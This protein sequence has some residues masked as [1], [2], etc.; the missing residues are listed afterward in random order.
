MKRSPGETQGR[1]SHLDLKCSQCGATIS[2]EKI[3]EKVFQCEYCGASNVVPEKLWNYLHPPAGPIEGG[4]PPPEPFPVQ[5]IPEAG[6]APGARKSNPAVIVLV[7]FSVLIIGGVVGFVMV[8]RG[9]ASSSNTSAGPAEIVSESDIVPSME[10][11]D[12]DRTMAR[13]FD[14][15]RKNWN[16]KALIGE[17]YISRLR[18]DGTVDLKAGDGSISMQF[19]VP[20]MAAGLLPGVT[21]IKDA[22]CSVYI[23]GNIINPSVGDASLYDI[24]SGRFASALPAC[25]VATLVK[26]AHKKGWPEAGFSTVS[27]PQVPSNIESSWDTLGLPSY[28]PGRKKAEDSGLTKEQDAKLASLL[29]Q[30]GWL[31]NTVYTFRYY[32]DGFDSGD[33]PSLFSF[34]D[35]RPVESYVN[36]PEFLG[37]AETVEEN[38]TREAAPAVAKLSTRDIQK[39]FKT[40]I[41]QIKKC[42]EKLLAADP[43]VGT[44]SLPVTVNIG[45]GGDVKSVSV[46]WKDIED[47][48]FRK[49]LTDSIMKWSFPSS[50]TSYTITYPIVLSGG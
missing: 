8:L 15:V 23:G 2:H 22:K 24:K 42:F 46:E 19:F 50:E 37:I 25:P 27:F 31:E 39:V 49:C 47:K 36:V 30:K 41:P 9:P 4:G 14:A 12:P 20:D 11:V 17:V 1:Q 28:A 38:E 3:R 44:V 43:N 33:L 32:V 48:A 45:S 35:C 7:A 13:I 18:A 10:K 21:E 26:E 29:A 16:P 40:H 34:K 6:P 5:E